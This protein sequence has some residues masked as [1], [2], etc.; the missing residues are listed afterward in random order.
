MAEPATPD[1]RRAGEPE[2]MALRRLQIAMDEA[3]LALGRRLRMNPSDLAAMGHVAGSPAPLGPT[4]LAGRLGMSPGATTELV[5]R[6]ERAGH[7]LRER[8]LVD[9]R[10]VRLVPSASART[11]VMGRLG[12]LLDAL[13]ALAADFDDDEREVVQRYLDRATAAYREYAAGSDD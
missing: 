3:Q 13:D 1:E 7:L 8:D 10:R 6:L 5:D 9:R 11:A 2:T 4:D 12:A